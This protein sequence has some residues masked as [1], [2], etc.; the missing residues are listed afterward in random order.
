MR[1]LAVLA[2]AATAAL[3]VSAPAAADPPG[4]NDD[5]DCVTQKEFRA[6]QNGDSKRFVHRTF[7]FKGRQVQ[8]GPP[9]IRQYRV[10]DEWESARGAHVRVHFVNRKVIFKEKSF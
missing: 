8:A 2:V 1:R 10:C 9:E 6:I 5:R 4:D 3:A 7:D